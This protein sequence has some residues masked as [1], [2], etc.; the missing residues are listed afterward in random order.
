MVSFERKYYL[1]ENTDAIVDESANNYNSL[2]I[3]PKNN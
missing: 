1:I 2:V 3:L